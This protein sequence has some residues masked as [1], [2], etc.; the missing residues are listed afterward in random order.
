MSAQTNITAT[1]DCVGIV[2]E[3]AIIIA[4][5]L[6]LLDPGLLV[7]WAKSTNEAGKKAGAKSTEVNVGLAKIAFDNST[8]QASKLEDALKATETLKKN[9][10]LLISTART[11]QTQATAK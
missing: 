7:R 3:L 10:E 11:P 4:V 9:L 5:V 6:V 8:E 2:R 1:K